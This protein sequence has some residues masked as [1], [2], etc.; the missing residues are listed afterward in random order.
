MNG[1]TPTTYCYD[2]ADRLT[3]TSEAA[4][5]ESNTADGTLAYDQ[6]GN[7]SVLGWQAMTYDIADRHLSTPAARANTT[8]RL[9]QFHSWSRCVRRTTMRRCAAPPPRMDGG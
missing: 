6:H 8:R 1:G 9:A 7:T 2:H 3:A 4:T 5:V